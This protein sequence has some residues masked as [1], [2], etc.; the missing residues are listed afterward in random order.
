MHCENLREGE[1]DT[2]GVGEEG[3]PQIGGN[4]LFDISVLF[5]NVKYFLVET[6]SLSCTAFLQSSY[7][8]CYFFSILSVHSFPPTFSLNMRFSYALGLHLIFSN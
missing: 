5:N 4:F 2:G 6:H 8:P 7:L 3:S 1:I